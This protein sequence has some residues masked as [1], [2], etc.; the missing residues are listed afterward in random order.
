MLH[1]FNIILSVYCDCNHSY[2]PHNAH[3][4]YKITNHPWTLKLLR[5]SSINRQPQR[6]VVQ[7]HIKAT[8]P[9]YIVFRGSTAPNRPRPPHCWGL[10]MTPDTPYSVGL[11]WTSDQPDAEISTWQHTPLTEDI[12]MPPAGI[13]PAIPVREL[14]LRSAQFTYKSQK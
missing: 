14:P 4:L 11:L 9:I 7:R 2:T 5:V 1:I 10:A 12:F 8:R 6:H 3:I 13:E